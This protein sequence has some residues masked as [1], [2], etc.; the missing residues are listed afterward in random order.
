[1][2]LPLEQ[3]DVQISFE[4]SE[5]E[6]AEVLKP[7]WTDPQLL[8]SQNGAS[9]KGS[10]GPFG[11]LVLASKDLKENTAVFF[12]ILNAQNKYVVL[13]CSDQSRSESLL[14]YFAIFKPIQKSE[15]LQKAY[16]ILE[17]FFVIS[18]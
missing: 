5:F 15:I 18:V 11:L 2:F 8:C 13:M 17:P 10:V 6:K 1:M 9:V 3:A 12:R 7:N 16:Q 4:I 14:T